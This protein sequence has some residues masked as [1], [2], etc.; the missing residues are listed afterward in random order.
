[1]GLRESSQRKMLFK[2]VST[3]DNKHFCYWMK[4]SH[5]KANHKYTWNTE[6]RST[7]QNLDVCACFFFLFKLWMRLSLFF[8]SSR[9]CRCVLERFDCGSAVKP[10]FHFWANYRM[11]L[12]ARFFCC[13]LYQNIEKRLKV[14]C[15]RR[16]F[17]VDYK[18]LCAADNESSPSEWC[19]NETGFLYR[20]IDHMLFVMNTALDAHGR[21]VWSEKECTWTIYS[22]M[23]D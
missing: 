3:N 15:T 23:I 21:T 8:F 17:V 4:W 18:A 16:V 10:L 9:Y 6:W 12:L 1:M 7:A 19:V 11:I 14:P 20:K 22:R 5:G 2:G 13:H